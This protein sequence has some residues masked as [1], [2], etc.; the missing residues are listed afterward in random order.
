[1]Q[2]YKYLKISENN[3]I[4]TVTISKP[5]V[6]ALNQESYLEI[7]D[8][9]N[10]LNQRDDVQVVIFCSEGKGFLGGNDISEIR[11]HTKK[12]HPQYQK[13]IADCMTSIL[14]CKHPV[15]AAVQGYSIGAGLV[16]AS[17]CDMVVAS[18][19]AWFNVPELSLGVIAGASFLM[20]FLPEKV[21]RYL[22]Y[23][24]AHISAK[25]M[26]DLGAINFVVPR[27]Q[28]LAKAYEIAEKIA[29]QPPTALTYFK[30]VMNLHYN[31]QFANKFL[32][33]TAY[34]GRILDTPEKQECVNA[35]F[36]KRK[37]VFD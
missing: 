5:P 31:H 4:A 24:G 7:T 21:V 2:Q 29:A 15:I 25:E 13:I 16:V 14:E 3:K 36:E 6:N 30:E 10:T 22:C 23:T 20:A 26:L 18:E 35:F 37:P 17:S 28:L 34:T 9:F 11:S 12:N 33:E 32:L 1:V 19:D 27:E 8:A